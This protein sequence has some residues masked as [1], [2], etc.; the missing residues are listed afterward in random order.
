MAATNT[1]I[2]RAAG[3]QGHACRDRR[4]IAVF[5]VDPAVAV[6]V[7]A[8]VTELGGRHAGAPPPVPPRPAAPPVPAAPARPPRPSPPHRPCRPARPPR[9]SPPRRPCRPAR[10]PRRCP[11]RRPCRRCR[12][13]PPCHPR[14]HVRRHCRRARCR[15]GGARG[16]AWIRPRRR[17]RRRLRRSPAAS[18]GQA[19]GGDKH[20]IDRLALARRGEVFPVRRDGDPVRLQREIDPDISP[21]RIAP[22]ELHLD[23]A[24][25]RAGRE[26]QL[27]MFWT[28]AVDVDVDVDTVGGDERAG[29]HVDEHGAR[30]QLCSLSQARLASPASAT[31]TTAAPMGSRRAPA[32]SP[33]LITPCLAE[34]RVRERSS[35][36][37]ASRIAVV[38]TSTAAAPTATQNHVCRVSGFCRQP[39]APTPW[40]RSCRP[41]AAARTAE[42]RRRA[43]SSRPAAASPAARA[44]A[45]ADGGAADGAARGARA[46]GTAG[47]GRSSSIA[48][49]SAATW[50]RASSALVP[51]GYSRT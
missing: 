26:C 5:A 19:V 23:A 13:R 3:I 31:T 21:C 38:P 46:T 48:F 25:A 51:S 28:D 40:A 49:F 44:A 17:C 50:L 11:P 18:A 36:R 47:G 27:G 22:R 4:A 12:P 24:A 35:P 32:G 43:S 29:A 6:V 30:G 41:R 7:G 9:P 33:A 39:P 16:S 37:V 42:G 14:R 15:A 34:R 8:V 2:P 45:A 20:R 1:P 10:P